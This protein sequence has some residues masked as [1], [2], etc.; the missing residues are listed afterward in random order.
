MTTVVNRKQA[1]ENQLGIN[2]VNFVNAVKHLFYIIFIRIKIT[3]MDFISPILVF[4]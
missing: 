1:T 3:A 4:T 2:Q